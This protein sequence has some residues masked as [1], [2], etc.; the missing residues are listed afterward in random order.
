MVGKHAEWSGIAKDG[1]KMVNA[2]RVKER[3]RGRRAIRVNLKENR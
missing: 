1:A 3:K 2:V